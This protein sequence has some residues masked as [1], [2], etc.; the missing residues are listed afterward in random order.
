MC[1]ECGQWVPDWT[2]LNGL[3][4]PWG[5]ALKLSTVRI[6]RHWLATVDHGDPFGWHPAHIE[7]Q[8]SFE[9]VVELWPGDVC[10]ECWDEWQGDVEYDEP[11][12]G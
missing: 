1:C 10:G 6:A 3:T 2:A 12:A 7:T 8:Q 11:G 5:Y 9:A 4:D